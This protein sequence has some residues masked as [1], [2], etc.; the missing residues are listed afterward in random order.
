MCGN[1]FK[2]FTDAVTVAT[3]GKD[4]IGNVETVMSNS[5]NSD[6]GM[7]GSVRRWDEGS[8]ANSL[9][10]DAN[11]KNDESKKIGNAG[12]NEHRR[13]GAMGIASTRAALIAQE[14]IQSVKQTLGA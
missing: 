6:S 13:S 8:K 1:P 9:Y 5:A 4:I 11:I 14:K 10:A 3:S 2:P 12:L 7:L